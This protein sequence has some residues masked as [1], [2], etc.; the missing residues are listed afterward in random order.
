[1][2]QTRY[3]TKMAFLVSPLAGQEQLRSFEPQDRFYQHR[4]LGDLD[5][6]EAEFD[7][8][9]ANHKSKSPLDE[10]ISDGSLRNFF[11]KSGRYQTSG[12]LEENLINY[13]LVRQSK[14]VSNFAPKFSNELLKLEG[15][16]RAVNYPPGTD[17]VMQGEHSNLMG[18]LVKGKCDILVGGTVVGSLGSGDSFGETSLIGVLNKR[19]ATIRTSTFCDV[20]LIYTSGFAKCVSMVPNMSNE[21]ERLKSVWSKVDP[22][23]IRKEPTIDDDQAMRA[24]KKFT[25]IWARRLQK[26]SIDETGGPSSPTSP[27]ASRPLAQTAQTLMEM[28]RSNDG[29]TS[30]IGHFRPGPKEKELRQTVN[31]LKAELV[32]KRMKG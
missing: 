15:H 21:L 29:I 28:R 2:I 32:K 10:A 27:R 18:V 13:E 16:M 11:V 8:N 7:E 26:Q 23:P 20:R 19:P 1:M 24:T 22:D 25:E 6:R 31:E 17:I 3:Q 4:N 12:V 9:T 30:P 5:F 14:F